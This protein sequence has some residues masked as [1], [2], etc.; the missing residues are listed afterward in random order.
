MEEKRILGSERNFIFKE[1]KEV[2]GTD[3]IN[4][5]F[6]FEG[7][8]F[9]VCTRGNIKIRIN[10]K[11]YCID[12]KWLFVIPPKHIFSVIEYSSDFEAQVLFVSMDVARDI[13]VTPNFSLLKTIGDNPC[14]K[15]SSE[16]EEDMVKLYSI[17][18][19]YDGSD[20]NTL[21]IRNTL[22]LSL[23]FISVSM[24]GKSVLHENTYS[25]QEEI[26]KHFFELLFENYIKERTVSFYANKLYVTSKYFSMS[27]KSVTGFPAQDW[28][29]E[30]V[31]FEA[32]KLLKTTELNIRQI[33][34]KLNFP[35]SSSFVRF[36]R[37]HIGKTP[38]EFRKCE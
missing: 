20:D 10:Y 30:V 1:L 34:D 2:L 27:V 26:T 11:E 21:L 14:V 32:K 3:F 22:I 8:M 16:K 28:I 23:I 36:F 25:R 19:K 18:E 9:N 38:L 7:F 33:S 15:L 24:Y 31:L 5:T 13:P 29:N 35:D 37:I 4:K 12:N 6:I 17:I